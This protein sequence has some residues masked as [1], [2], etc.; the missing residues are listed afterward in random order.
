MRL[1]RIEMSGFKTFRDRAVLDF[2][3]GL[4]AI[5]GPNGCGK[6]N[7]VDAIRWV[8]GEQRVRLLRG[9]KM[10]DVIFHGSQDVAPFGMAEI[11]MTLLNEGGAFPP[12]YV[13]C[14]EVTV[15][16][17]V[18]RDGESEYAI[19]N[20]PCRLVDVRE[21]F[22]DTGV[23]V[24]TYSIVEQ[25]SVA[26]LVE[27]KPEERRQF[28]E[29]AAGIA[30]YKS[31][32]EA[33]QRKM[34]ATRENLTRLRD[35]IREVK[36]GVNALTKQAKRAEQY[37]ELRKR[38][39]DGEIT[40]ALQA[41]LDLTERR[42]RRRGECE[43]R[44]R[45]QLSLKS[46]CEKGESAQEAVK[47]ELLDAETAAAGMQQELYELKNRISSREQ[48]I[49]FAEKRIADVLHRRQTGEADI[50]AATAR[51]AA[52]AKD[53]E[54]LAAD[55]I[56]AEAQRLELNEAVAQQRAVMDELRTKDEEL[57][58]TEEDRKIFYFDFVAEK[59]RLK[60]AAAGLA[61]QQEDLARRADRGDR[62]KQEYLAQAGK[63]RE[64]IAAADASL[65]DAAATLHGDTEAHA[66]LAV[67]IESAR[68]EVKELEAE[69][70]HLREDMSRKAARLSSLREFRDGYTWCSESTKSL[71]KASR[72]EKKDS[73][74]TG[75]FLGVVADHIETPREYE[76]AVEA[77]LGDKLQYIVVERHEDALEAI[78]YL[79]R[80]AL[81]KSTFV[82]LGVRSRLNGT[83]KVTSPGEGV[84]LRELVSTAPDFSDIADYLFGDVVV[85]PNLSRGIGL[86]RR[87]GFIG[88][89][90]TP[91]GDIIS[92]H[93]VM[94]GGGGKE[95][96]VGL[97]RIKREIGELTGETE[98]ITERLSVLTS[99]LGEFRTLL[100]KD[101]AE[102]ARLK[103]AI[104]NAELAMTRGAKDRER[105][106]GELTLC[107]QRMRIIETDRENLATEEREL[108]TRS[109]ST[110]DALLALEAQET[111]VNEAMAVLQRERTT[112]AADLKEREARL[113]EHKVMLA[114]LEERMRNGAR[115][116]ERI[117]RDSLALAREIESKSREAADAAGEIET[118]SRQVEVG[119][120]HVKEL[121]GQLG[122]QE[123]SLQES[124]ETQ[125]Q[126]EQAFRE[127]EAALRETRK[128]LETM[129]GE[130]QEMEVDVRGLDLRIEGL[131]R[132]IREKFTDEVEERMESFQRL[133]PE[134][135]A[136][137]ERI[138]ADNRRSLDAFGEVNL[139]AA[140]EY[141]QVK[142]RYDFLAAQEHDLV[143][144]LEALGRTITRINRITRKRFRETYEAVNNHF[145]AV[146]A[147]IFPG[148][149]GEL[150]LTDEADLLETGVDIDVQIPGKRAQSVSLLSGGEKSLAAIALIFAILLHRPSPFLVL[151]EVDAA[152]DD[153]NVA[154]FT[155]LL[156][157]LAMHSQVIM[158]THNKRSMEAA[159]TLIGVTMQ[160]QGISTIVSVNLNT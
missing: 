89:F 35:I 20:I 23:G 116:R 29:E 28:I 42:E 12:P 136:E 138:L 84:K 103:G 91:E 67:Q 60:N 157:D 135:I 112:L 21:F 154:L 39:R 38:T 100:P 3:E 49:S 105:M 121:Y 63:L 147:R 152:L 132:D 131:T 107:E 56:A 149:R 25:N 117:E 50:E 134:Q 94:T 156:A 22:M 8:M 87:N 7:A 118:L 1:K 93:G 15:S 114:S 127:G 30:K 14:A 68:K 108:R 51:R 143:T 45:E 44:R 146:F 78:D 95:R 52:A 9:K 151:D 40:L 76:T 141:E 5:V 43:A 119:R 102:L 159:R 62:E 31:R 79:K 140:S 77:V 144:S 26:G 104:H 4:N 61:R 88:T 90:V 58:R 129:N 32:K 150:R 85:I 92:P 96:D 34:E 27:A 109:E 81:G 33:A 71:L 115:T 19:N 16:R 139:L 98:A 123:A 46:V 148:G 53:L 41:Y 47:A 13:E 101:E 160:K 72:H 69:I 142:E 24:R 106:E 70:A 36:T 66:L 57:R 158:V 125:R 111:A 75:T 17:R 122:Q 59:A 126:R 99:R 83:P 18:F 64:S 80:K 124:K 73:P 55:L 113:T 54:A 37:R 2:T 130:L 128:A 137:S 10:D 155:E 145:Q 133:T 48:G 82:P 86:W 120:A 6:S 74:A 11:A 153:A 110:S 65:A 97:L